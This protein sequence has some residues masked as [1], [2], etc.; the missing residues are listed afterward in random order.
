MFKPKRTPPASE[1]EASLVGNR[2]H[3]R[4][5]HSGDAAILGVAPQIVCGRLAHPPCVFHGRQRHIQTDLVA[6]FEAIDH[7]LGR[8]VDPYLHP[9]AQVLF[10][11]CQMSSTGHLNHP[12]RRIVDP[13]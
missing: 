3:V 12:N 2:F 13:G 6:M 11:A 5:H 8:T 10:D 1:A 7:G 9:V 4:A